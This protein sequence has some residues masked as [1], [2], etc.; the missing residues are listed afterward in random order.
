MSRRSIRQIVVIVVL[1]IIL[2]LLGVGY[3]NY[4]QTR[5]FGLDIAFNQSEMLTPP[6]YLYSF[7]GEGEDR[8]ARPLGVLA[9]G[10]RIYVTDSRR[11]VV[12]VFTATGTH[13][14]T[15]GSEVLVTPLYLAMHPVSGDLYV[16][17]RRLRSI[18][19]FGP[20]GAHKGSFDPMLPEEELPEFDTQGV[21]WAPVALDFAAD[22]SLYVAE[23]LKGHRLLI[24]APD[25]AFKRS[26][27]TAGLVNDAKSGEAV[28]QFPNSVKVEGDEVWV[29]DSNNRRIQVFD[30]DGEFS[31]LVVTQGL[32]RGFDFL[33]KLEE[34]EP[35]RL[36]VIDT[37]AHDAT[38]WDAGRAQKVL[39]FGGRGVLEGQFN[40]PND[41]S[42]D[43]QRRIF[44]AD[45]AN[46][47]IQVWGWPALSNPVPLPT[48]PLGWLA[49]LSPLLLLPLLLLLRR[50]RY[51]VTP[52]F[53]QRLIELGEIDRM[54]GRRVRWE[55]LA[56]DHDQFVGV[57]Q[58]GVDLGTL[59]NPVE[60]SEADAREI[61]TRYELEWRDAAVMSVAQ[62]TKRFAT[63]D[64]D[65][66]RVAVALE[67]RVMDHQ[68]FLAQSPRKRGSASER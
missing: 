58:D 29:S 33:P 32:P 44:V 59:L 16:S 5:S 67:L 35:V 57:E 42:I 40:Y 14:A 49:C 47:R 46:G 27:G 7:A 6:Q 31:R 39:T 1:L 45:T 38:I 22:G 34:E 50:K 10:G 60:F 11:G 24:F 66:R 23:I 18:E 28:F 2:A 43:A 65:L 36:V 19:I 48:T 20:D 15:W 13:T 17:D 61:E 37:L 41:T 62:R 64:R 55:I 63:E 56:F 3:W 26:V 68:E 53:V 25:G 8:L 4:S 9:E 52:D 54:P 30:L 12:D 51:V 21:Q